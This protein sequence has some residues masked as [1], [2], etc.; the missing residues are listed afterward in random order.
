RGT[1]SAGEAERM[2]RT[3][4]A[5][6][7]TPGFRANVETLMAAAGRDKKNR[8]GSRR[9]VLPRGIGDAVVVEDVTD[10]EMEEA[11]RWVLKEA[12]RSR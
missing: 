1:V 5:Y 11:A 6:G 4:A 3:I 8:A 10:A 7:P 2:E 12:R 9:F